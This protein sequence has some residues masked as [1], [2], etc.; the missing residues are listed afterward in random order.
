VVRNSGMLTYLHGDLLPFIMLANTP[1]VVVSLFYLLFN[2]ILT[3]M[4]GNAEWASYATKRKPL[5]TTTPEG[6]QRSTFWLQLPYR[7]SVPYLITMTTLHWAMSQSLFFMRLKA[8]SRGVEVR[9]KDQTGLAISSDAFLMTVILF[10]IVTLVIVGLGFFKRYPPGLPL[11]G[12]CSV[13]IA[14]ASHKP[15]DEEG[16][17]LTPVRW[18]VVSTDVDGVGHCCFTSREVEMPVDGQLYA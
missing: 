1:Q 14:A 13:V 10:S 11:M 2:G 17:E 16:A 12:S 5:R 18:G 6:E 7:Y 15:L 8:Y 9:E 4:L 3:S